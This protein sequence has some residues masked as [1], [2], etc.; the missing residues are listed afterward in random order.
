MR[1]DNPSLPDDYYT[2]SFIAGL[3]D[4]TQAHLQCNKPKDLQDA[5]W[6]ARRLEQATNIRKPPFTPFSIKRQ[7][8]FDMPKTPMVPTPTLPSNQA[9]I[10]Q[11]RQK[12]ICFRCKEPWVPGHR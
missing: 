9:L 8:S 12:G 2:T 4:Y 3:S 10:Q 11:A 7:V 5:M 1:R 6:M